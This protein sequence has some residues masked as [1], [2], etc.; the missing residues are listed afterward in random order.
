MTDATLFSSGKLGDI[1][2]KNRILMAPLTR[3]RAHA[4]GTPSDLAPKYYAQRASAGLIISEASQISP[5]AQGYINTPGIYSDAHVEGWK[6]VTKAVHDKGGKIVLQL[7]HVGRISHTSIQPDGQAPVA[8]SAIQAK[9]QVF[10]PDGPAEA[11]MPRALEAN[12]IPGII[13][14]YRQAAIKAKEAGFDGVEIHAANGYLLDQ[15]QRDSTNKR[16]DAYGGSVENRIRLT[17]EVVD[18]VN[19]VFGAGAVGI[20]LSPTGKFND[21]S[22]SDPAT[23]FGALIDA[24]NDKGLAY[25]HIVENFGAP[26]SEDELAILKSLRKRWKGAY[27]AN[28]GYDEKAVAD[29]VLKGGYADAIAY[30][31]LFISNPDLPARL[32]SGAAFNDMRQELF[33][34]GGAEGYVDYPTLDEATQAA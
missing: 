15:F 17:T 24:L 9:T 27:I 31:R 25:L 33:Y 19:S 6:A 5:T 3:S 4:N 8:P 1:D 29:K 13:E 12:E 16:I 26:Q 32:E 2:I 7:W 14:E 21:L 23:T 10:T 28:G 22:D 34:M 11:S 20:R 18:A 30:G